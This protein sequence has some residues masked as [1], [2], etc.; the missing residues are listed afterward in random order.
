MTW[1]FCVFACW[2]ELMIALVVLVIYFAELEE[3]KGK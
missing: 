3:R 1:P 2:T